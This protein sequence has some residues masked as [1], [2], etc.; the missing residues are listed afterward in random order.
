MTKNKLYIRLST[1]LILILVFGVNINGKGLSADRALAQEKLETTQPFSL[2]SAI[3]EQS[4][5]IQGPLSYSSYT[6]ITDN[7][8][9]IKVQIK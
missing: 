1:L 2:P 9:K 4:P 6:G 8:E 3:Q 5:V 7:E